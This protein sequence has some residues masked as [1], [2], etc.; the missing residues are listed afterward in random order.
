MYRSAWIAFVAMVPNVLP[1]VIP[2]AAFGILGIMLDAPAVVIAS[3][4][5]GVAIDDTIHLLTKFDTARKKGLAPREALRRTFR[6]IGSAV[7]STTIVLVVG[8]SV[9]NLS[10]YHPNQMIGRLACFMIALAW[11]ADFVVTPALLSY[12]PR[13]PAARPQGEAG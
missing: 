12:L 5:L 3:I 1:I 6:E 4:A 10:A 8:F 9:M 11:L 13:R 7:T 2:L